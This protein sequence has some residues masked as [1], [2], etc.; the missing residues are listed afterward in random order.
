MKPHTSDV[1]DAVRLGRATSAMK[2]PLRLV[3]LAIE[4]AVHLRRLPADLHYELVLRTVDKDPELD[5]KELTKVIGEDR[6]KLVEAF[7][8]D[9]AVRH[10]SVFPLLNAL[11]S[12][13]I[14]VAGAGRK[15]K[16]SDWA[17]QALLEAGLCRMC[18]QGLVKL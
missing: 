13:Q 5:L 9:R 10:S 11:T 4:A 17:A 18:H 7:E 15:R 2:E 12:G 3:A 14:D 8:T 1:H 16:T 6:A